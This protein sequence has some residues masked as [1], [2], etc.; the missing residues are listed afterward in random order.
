MPMWE[1]LKGKQKTLLKNVPYG[2]SC[3]SCCQG[4]LSKFLSKNTLDCLSQPGFN[5]VSGK[6]TKTENKQDNMVVKPIGKRE[7]NKLQDK[8]SAREEYLSCRSNQG[9]SISVYCSSSGGTRYFTQMGERKVSCFSYWVDGVTNHLSFGKPSISVLWSFM[10]RKLIKIINKIIFH[11]L[12]WSVILVRSRTISV[13]ITGLIRC[14]LYS[15]VSSSS[16]LPFLF[17]FLL[18]LIINLNGFIKCLGPNSGTL[19]SWQENTH[20]LSCKSIYIMSPCP[21]QP[22]PCTLHIPSLQHHSLKG[23]FVPGARVDVWVGAL[24]D[25]DDDMFWSSGPTLS[26]LII[27]VW[28]W[29][30]VLECTSVDLLQPCETPCLG[31]A[32]STHSVWRAGWPSWTNTWDQIT[33]TCKRE[34]EE[35]WPSEMAPK[36]SHA[37]LKQVYTTGFKN[38]FL[39]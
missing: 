38:L 19:H 18:F 22:R 35:L 31:W 11:F 8:A 9:F 20:I 34:E 21:G 14:F 15:F 13:I 1:Q 30:T 7:R 6:E 12:F 26:I 27:T 33:G 32:F 3:G 36:S 25:W 29:S 24:I 2:A 17:S 23:S 10:K 37:R 28:E 16:L 39:T 4:N 5:L